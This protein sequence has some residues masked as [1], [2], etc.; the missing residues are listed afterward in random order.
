MLQVLKATG[1]RKHFFAN[2]DM[3]AV[4]EIRLLVFILMELSAERD[5]VISQF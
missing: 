2:V 1:H 3:L 4:R 5:I